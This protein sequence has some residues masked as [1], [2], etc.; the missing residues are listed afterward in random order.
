MIE[1]P[2]AEVVPAEKPKEKLPRLMIKEIILENFKSYGGKKSI[3]P[4]HKCFSSIVGPNG[5]GKSNTIDALLFVFGKRAKKIRLNKASE[6]IHS[7]KGNLSLP[8][9]KVTVKFVDIIDTGDRADDYEVVPGSEL[10][11]SREALRNNQSRYYI[12]GELSNFTEV[13]TLLRKRGVD[14]EHNRF[15]ILQGEVEQ[16]A[17]MKPK[18]QTQHDDGFL[19]YLEDII[20]S[21]RHVESIEEAEA[22][23]ERLGEV[24]Q[25]KLNRLRVAER[26][27]ESLDGPRKEAE[28]WVTNEGERLELQ[29]LLA[30]AEAQHGH[31]AL[32]T[33]EEE[34]AALKVHM[35]EHQRKMEVYEKEAKAIE[36]EHNEHLKDYTGMKDAMEKASAEFKE[37]ERL[38]VKFTEDIAFLEQKLVKFKQTSVQEEEQA[39]RLVAEAQR[40]RTEAPTK[41]KELESADRF[42]ES[43]Q[44]KLEELYASLKGK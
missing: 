41:E 7:S 6:L 32:V 37:F 9:A 44:Q 39:A 24:R 31:A 11:V 28:I 21:N 2:A 10:S 29:A 23:M 15:L 3:G 27:R 35:N 30:Q 25:E 33:L 14:L 13:T 42:R 20:G 22:A 34:H 36:T 4:F 5:S 43:Q 19:E 8:S 18:A 38:D 26:E 1:V 17:L 40:I 12:E 16:I